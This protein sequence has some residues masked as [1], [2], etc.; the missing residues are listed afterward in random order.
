MNNWQEWMCGTDPTNSASA[1][2][3]LELVY[4]GSASTV[5]WQSV[6]DRVYFVQRSTNLMLQ[7][8]FR[9]VG[10]N[11]LGQ[12]GTTRHNDTNAFG[13]GP[14]YYRVGIQQ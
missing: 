1:L 12:A 8:I 2:R 5:T 6:T 14:C 10:S 4:T 9:V 11:I 3:M 13:A 7:P